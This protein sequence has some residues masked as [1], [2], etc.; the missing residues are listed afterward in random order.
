MNCS[1][2]VDFLMAYLDGALATPQHETFEAHM[3]DCPSCET[4]LETYRETIQLG[5]LCLS[6]P[7][8]PVP[9]QVPEELVAA[10][11]AARAV[12]AGGAAGAGLLAR[13]ASLFCGFGRRR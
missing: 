13:L 10:I 3:V 4:F 12:P 5:K 8:G 9:A 2:F 1:E 11:L 7:E 6:E